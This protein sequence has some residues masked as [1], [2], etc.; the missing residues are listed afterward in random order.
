MKQFQF[1]RSTSKQAYLPALL[2]DE[3]RH[4]CQG[5]MKWRRAA[6]PWLTCT[7]RSQANCYSRDDEHGPDRAQTGANANSNSCVARSRTKFGPF[8][9]RQPN[10]R[11]DVA[12]MNAL[13][14]T[15]IIRHL[16]LI[17]ARLAQW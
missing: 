3:D 15:V 6:S 1:H 13:D 5:A 2:S 11:I 14:C 4:L 8:S 7:R 17:W 9:F 16:S 12:T 10:Q